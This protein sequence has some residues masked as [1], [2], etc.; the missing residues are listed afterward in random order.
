MVLMNTCMRANVIIYLKI[1]FEF[2]SDISL[3]TTK[4][5]VY[6]ITVD[7]LFI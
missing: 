4:N 7:K 1:P 2:A 5:F 3:I 6:I